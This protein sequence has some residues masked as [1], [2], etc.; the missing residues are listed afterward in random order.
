MK[1]TLFCF[2]KLKEAFWKDACADY[3]KR[4]QPYAKTE[5]V[6]FPDEPIEDNPT[7]AE[8]EKVNA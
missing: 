4:L 2:G 1:I 5:I 7:P 6:E 8:I 3:L